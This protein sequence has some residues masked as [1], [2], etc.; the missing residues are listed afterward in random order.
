MPAASTDVEPFQL[1]A[2][3]TDVVGKD[4]FL[5]G[6][7]FSPDG[8]C[9]L[10]HSAA[11]GQLR[12]YNTPSPP[13]DESSKDL[14]MK[15]W[16]TAL[17]IDGGDSVRSY[18]WYPTMNSSNPATCCFLATAR[19]QPIHLYDAYSGAVRATY[20]PY[21]R[22]DEMEAPNVVS[23]SGD[24]QQIVAG[25][26]RTDRTLHIFDTA[27]PGR[28]SKTILHLGKTRRSNDGQKGLVSAVSF[29]GGGEGSSPIVAVGTYA[30]GS[31][32]IYDLRSGQQPTG[33]ILNG[34]CVVG[35]GVGNSRKKR[36]FAETTV[37]KDNA[38][39]GINVENKDDGNWFSNAKAKWFRTK[40]QGGVTQLEYSPSDS[41]ILY[42]SSRRSNCIISWDLRMLSG[43]TDHQSNPV[44][45][46]SSYAT[47]NDTNQRIE[48]DIES[49]G[50]MLYVGSTDS[51][52]M[53]YDLASAEHTGTLDCL[54]LGV[55]NGVTHAYQSNGASYLAVATGSRQFPTEEDIENER[56]FSKAGK[57][58]GNL[59]LYKLNA[60]AT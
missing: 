18:A 30:P 9:V 50:K 26:F 21:N 60:D 8:L 19:E 22:L 55:V 34:L 46:L 2:R 33:T 13:Q 58:A 10:T 54:D 20:S 56:D 3:S 15:D 53:I 5:K 39:D 41:Y 14:Q 24:G 11:D 7:Q 6:C 23:F 52:I 17:S 32:Y 49:K 31:I 27:L 48:F 35:H 4:N 36:R 25:G 59:L 16:K 29:G 45:G 12:L 1:V 38:S 44:R 51:R 28:T 43:N 40:A 42:S 57:P 47:N 37:G